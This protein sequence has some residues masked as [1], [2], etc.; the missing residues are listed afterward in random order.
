M[1]SFNSLIVTTDWLFKVINEEVFQLKREHLRFI[2][3]PYKV[4]KAYLKKEI[5][6]HL[7]EGESKSWD[8]LHIPDWQY[9]EG[10]PLHLGRPSKHITLCR[11]PKNL[12]KE[13]WMLKKTASIHGQR[14]KDKE[15]E[16]AV[17]KKMKEDAA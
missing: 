13:L 16:I 8:D 6:D 7:P 12:E 10:L 11:R 9:L 4:P 1:P 5:E 14:V 2:Q 17:K 15:H 3:L